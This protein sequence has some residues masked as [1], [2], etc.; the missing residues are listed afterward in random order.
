MRSSLVDEVKPCGWDLAKWLQRLTVNAKVA[1][2]LDSIP[3]SSDTV[4][5]DGRQ[6]KQCW[7]KY[8]VRKNRKVPP[9]K[10]NW[11]F[12][13]SMQFFRF[14]SLISVRFRFRFFL[15]HAIFR[16]IFVSFRFFRF[17]LLIS[18]SFLLQIFA[19]SLRC[20]PSEI[21]LFFR[22][23]TKLNFRFNFN[24]RFWSENE[25]EPYSHDPSPPPA[26]TPCVL[27]VFWQ[28]SPAGTGKQTAKF[29]FLCIFFWLARVCWPLLRLCRSFMIF[30]GSLDSNPEYCRSKL[31]RYR[32]SQPP[33]P[34]L[35]T[36][37]SDWATHPSP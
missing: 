25:G 5:S 14:I 22:F 3:A 27:T 24:F 4:E 12:F 34:L 29:Y 2:V 8:I 37:P 36:H 17:F 7:I 10:N 32:L 18:H 23:Q 9:L 30:D 21:M 28:K 6:M 26:L 20:E 15:G 19:V 35:A 11:F 13:V 16:F 33:I 31:A 1:T